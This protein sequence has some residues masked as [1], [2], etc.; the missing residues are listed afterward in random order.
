M[1]VGG[2][3]WELFEGDPRGIRLFGTE[4]LRGLSY[5]VRDEDWGTFATVTEAERHEEGAEAMRYERRFRETGGTFHGVFTIEANTHATGAEIVATVRY[6]FQRDLDICRAGFTLLHPIKGVAGNE[7]TL[8]L[9]NGQTA[10]SH[11]PERIAAI[12]PAVDYIGMSHR[13]GPVEIDIAFEGESFEMEDQRNFSDA[14]FKTFCRPLA[15]PHPFQVSAGEEISQRVV[16]RMTKPASAPGIATQAEASSS[17]RG[18]LPAIAWAMDLGTGAPP[19]DG[20]PV[21]LRLPVGAEAAALAPV[22]GRAGVTLEIV[23]PEGDDG[24]KSLAAL[25][26]RCRAA[27]IDPT[28][29]VA[30]P[31]PYLKC[32]PVTPDWPSRPS[33][34][35]VIPPLRA[36]FPSAAVGG[37]SLTFFNEFNCQRPRSELVDFVT[38]GNTAIIHAADDASVMQTIEALAH[39]FDSASELAAGRPLHLGLIAIGVRSNPYGRDVLHNP[40]NVKMPMV[41]KDPRQFTEFAAAYAVGVLMVAARSGVASLALAMPDG[42]FGV[43][44]PQGLSPLGQLIGFAAS[45]A[46]AEV[47]IAHLPEGAWILRGAGR[48]IAANLGASPVPLPPPAGPGW[49]PLGNKTTAGGSLSELAAYSVAVSG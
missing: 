41:R 43:Q 28:R 15:K 48:S 37:G 42:D 45:L 26:A 2:L 46:G 29:V 24:T 33:L 44:G 19:S 7:M 17:A 21:L 38:F 39:V 14:S 27:G 49:R 13:A 6:V 25:A 12:P 20:L 36:A 32:F 34:E 3:S 10:R 11:F 5:P 22:A 47:E 1:T 40:D 18:V 23:L 16:L 4:V 31:E 35:D 8:R 9:A 30:L